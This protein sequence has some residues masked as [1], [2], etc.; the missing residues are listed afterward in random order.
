MTAADVL[1]GPADGLGGL[2]ADGEP[3]LGAIKIETHLL[4]TIGSVRG[5]RRCGATH[6]F[7]VLVGIRV[8]CA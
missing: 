3:I 8:I 6:F 2:G 1:Q 5:A 4:Q 7:V